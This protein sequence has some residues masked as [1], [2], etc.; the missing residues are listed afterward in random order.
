VVIKDWAPALVGYS[1]RS[2][3]LC[4]LGSS[5][6][7]RFVQQHRVR[8]VKTEANSINEIL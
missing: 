2:A 5:H 7:A 4:G 8:F 1:G 6:H 3:Q